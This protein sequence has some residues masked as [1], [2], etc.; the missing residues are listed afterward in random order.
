[1]AQ[2]EIYNVTPKLSIANGQAAVTYPGD[3]EYET[4]QAS[5]SGPQHRT[6]F[7]DAGMKYIHSG[8]DVSEPP[9]DRP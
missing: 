4:G 7:T 6:L 9:M 1:L 2:R 5:S 8:A 3:I